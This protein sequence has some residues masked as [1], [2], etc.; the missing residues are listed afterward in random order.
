MGGGRDEFG[1]VGPWEEVELAKVG[2]KPCGQGVATREG[3]A[4][5]TEVGNGAARQA[6]SAGA[7]FSIAAGLCLPLSGSADSSSI[8]SGLSEELD[9]L[10]AAGPGSTGEVTCLPRLSDRFC[11]K[12]VILLPCVPSQHCRKIQMQNGV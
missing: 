11:T 1:Q 4:G 2:R 5:G 6:T 9:S 3:R 12:G 7:S 8:A 10:P